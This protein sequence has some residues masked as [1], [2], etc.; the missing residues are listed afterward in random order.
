MH[1][2]RGIEKLSSKIQNLK[3]EKKSTKYEVKQQADEW[4]RRLIKDKA[5][6]IA[7]T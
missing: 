1:F 5:S 3:S 6:H 7:W 4:D 2:S